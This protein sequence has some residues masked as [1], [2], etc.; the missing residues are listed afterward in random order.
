MSTKVYAYPR[1]G[2]RMKL[3]CGLI[4]HMNVYTSHIIQQVFQ[5]RMQPKQDIPMPGEDDNIS[6]YFMSHELKK[7]TLKE[8]DIEG[9]HKDFLGK[10]L[11]T[12]SNIKDM[13]SRRIL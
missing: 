8:Q 13:L 3:I 4:R 2:K 5:T 12:G 9:D 6:D 7:S 1:C 11:D 10:S